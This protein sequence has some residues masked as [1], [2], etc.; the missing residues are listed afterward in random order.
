MYVR[1]CLIVCMYI[2]DGRNNRGED[3]WLKLQEG[4]AGSMKLRAKSMDDS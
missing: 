1:A 4:R 2:Q 3:R